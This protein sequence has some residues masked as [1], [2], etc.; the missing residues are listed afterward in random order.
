MKKF[1]KALMCV[2]SA[3]VVLSAAA[4]GNRAGLNS[5]EKHGYQNVEQDYAKGVTVAAKGKEVYKGTKEGKTRLKVSFVDAGFGSDWIRVIATHFVAENPDYW[6]FLD[7]DPAL[8][9]IV[10]TQL[11]AGVNL[12]DIYM[13]LAHDWQLYAQNGWLEDLSEVY[14]AKADGEAGKTVYDKMIPIWQDYCIA[15]GK[16]GEGKGKYAYPWSLGVS[17]IVYND[18]MFQK[19]N[20]EIPETMAELVALCEQIKKDTNGSVA[21]FVYPGLSGGYWDFMGMT[22]WLQSSGIEGFKKFMDFDSVEVYNPEQ[23]PG[24]GKLEALEAFDS[25]FGYGKGNDLKGSMSKNAQ[26]AQMNFLRQEAAMIINASW[27]ETEMINDI[28]ED[29]NIRF[30]RFPYIETAQKDSNGDYIKINYATT[31]DFMIVPKAIPEA[32]KAGAK[33]FLVYLSKDESL[34]YFTKYSSSLRPFDY[35]VTPVK[36]EL[37]DFARDVFE[38]ASTSENYFPMIS[39]KWKLTPC[40]VWYPTQPYSLLI[41]GLDNGGTTPLRFCKTEYQYAKGQWDDWMRKALPAI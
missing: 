13:P 10:G 21:P 14:D 19:Y 27:M 20:W 7:G 29:V 11:G 25:I 18:T 32:Q 22:H 28:P 4:C 37:S 3:S 31:P 30:M 24:K 35:D 2:L 41:F 5:S 9:T 34:R 36:D 6:I 23:Q 33:K 8:T 17:G 1:A 16:A 26:E 15:Y 39:K 12:S 38:I 40:P